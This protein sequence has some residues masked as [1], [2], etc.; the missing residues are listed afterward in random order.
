MDDT[1]D[2]LGP[3]AELAVFRIVTEALT[4]VARHSGAERATVRVLVDAEGVEVTVLDV[5]GTAAATWSPGG[6]L[7]SMRERV[8]QLGGQLEAGAGPDGGRVHVWLPAASG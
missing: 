2:A 4:N 3:A 5:G 1:L 8:D 7:R 6:G